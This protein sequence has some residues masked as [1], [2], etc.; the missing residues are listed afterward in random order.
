MHINVERV[1]RESPLPVEP[2]SIDA[3]HQR[4]FGPKKRHA[5][6]HYEIHEELGR[7]QFGRV[8]RSTDTRYPRQVALKVI[9][10]RGARQLARLEREAQALANLA[11]PNVVNVFEKGIA[12]SGVYFL[13]TELVPGARLDAWM[14]DPARR[15]EEILEIFAQAAEGLQHAHERGMIHR[16]FKPSNA[17]VDEDGRLRILDFGLVKLTDTRE[18]STVEMEATL[19][20]SER[21]LDPTHSSDWSGGDGA[22]PSGPEP[23]LLTREGLL[24]TLAYASPEQLD[25]KI[26]DSRSD[27]FSLCVALFEAC[28]GFRP[29]SGRSMLALSEQ[30]SRGKLARGAARRRVPGWLKRLL[31]R[32]L[33]PSPAERY[34]DVGEI[35]SILRAHLRPRTKPWMALVAGIGVTLGT[36]AGV[37]ALMRPP[38][39][40]LDWGGAWPEG[41]NPS[42]IGELYG[43]GLQASLTGYEAAWKNARDEYARSPAREPDGPAVQ[44]LRAGKQR[45][46]GFVADL[47]VPATTLLVPPALSPER[48][49]LAHFSNPD[50]CLAPAPAWETNDVLVERLLDAQAARLAGRYEEAREQLELVR[51]DP[52]VERGRPAG[53]LGYE[54][55]VVQLH[56]RDSSAWR[57]LAAAALDAGDDRELLVDVLARQ[58]DAGVVLE[59]AEPAEID[60]LLW[61]L[62]Q[63]AE[64][65]GPIVPFAEG[66]ALFHRG[67]F[68]DARRSY[69]HAREAFAAL[70][71]SPYRDAMIAQST[72]NEAY[73]E[74]N[75][76][77]PVVELDPLEP[78]LATVGMR[79]GE[80]HPL[81]LRHG[82]KVAQLLGD[83]GRVEQAHRLLASI[84]TRFDVDRGV[85]SSFDVVR[86]RAELLRLDLERNDYEGDGPQR[87]KWSATAMDLGLLLDAHDEGLAL[88]QRREAFHVRE[89]LLA[90][91][92]TASNDLRALRVLDEMSRDAERLGKVRDTCDYVAQLLE[93]A[94]D[95]K[96]EASE[97]ALEIEGRLRTRCG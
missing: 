11:H 66:Y 79:L 83:G 46:H 88:S 91:H 26:V 55:G 47:G 81:Y 2:S 38:E 59:A 41:A 22:A 40:D 72:L 92:D 56:L 50:E 48:I 43:P 3:V 49:W 95:E 90:A 64:A 51:D 33:S 37:Q 61:L 12:D 67:R 94:A 60:T 28:H 34:A 97:E 89:I 5:P 36:V 8:F 35:A 73:A 4:L 20:E 45:F 13:A 87:A 80:Q 52:A 78:A 96:I 76:D 16:D 21:V 14:R 54:L 24:G 39:I 77:A 44:C 71:A 27:Q 58:L 9:P 17:I 53:L 57:T 25:G 15:L 18:P 86:A 69:A 70:D 82:V 23:E 29:F 19:P 32:G 93:R 85:P 6:P 63:R 30:I 65:V 1:L 7:G 84:L 42:Q 75:D 62:L 31:R 10:Y 74:S 68:E